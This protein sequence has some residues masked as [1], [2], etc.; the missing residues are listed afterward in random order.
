MEEDLNASTVRCC[1]SIQNSLDAA[2]GLLVEHGIPVNGPAPSVETFL[3]EYLE[4][5]L[6]EDCEDFDRIGRIEARI[7]DRAN[8]TVKLFQ[9][10]SDARS[11]SSKGP[12]RVASST[13][14]SA[15]AGSGL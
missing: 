12:S 13:A 9:S 10:L 7:L 8:A 11:S 1:R 14:S 15:S 5:R 4:F 6:P 2:R 3:D